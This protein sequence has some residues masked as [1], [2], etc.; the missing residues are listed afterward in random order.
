MACLALDIKQRAPLFR[1]IGFLQLVNWIT[2]T[3]DKLDTTI[4]KEFKVECH[5]ITWGNKLSNS[6]IATIYASCN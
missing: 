5:K 1:N 6:D 2:N 3:E 4:I